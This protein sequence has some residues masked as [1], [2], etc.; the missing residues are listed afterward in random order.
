MDSYRVLFEPLHKTICVGSK[1]TL[2]EAA[3]KAGIILD[4]VCGGGRGCGRCKVVVRDGKVR[5]ETAKRLAPEE[6]ERGF[7]LACRAYPESDLLIEIP[8]ETHSADKLELDKDARRFRAIHPGIT[9]KQFAKSPLVRKIF[10]TLDRPTLD[11]NPGDYERLQRALKK[12]TG[13]S[14]VH[15]DLKLLCRLPQVLRENDFAVTVTVGTLGDTA[16]ILDIEGGNRSGRNCMA[17]VDVGTSTI[18]VHLVDAVEMTTLDAHACYN[19][20]SI[21][22]RE[23]TAR[24][25]ASEKR[26]GAH[27]QELVVGDINRL[28][29]AL[30][31]KNRIRLKDILA[32]VAAG[33]TTMAHFLL[34]LP[35]GNIRRN[36]YIAASIEPPPV[37]ATEVGIRIHPAGLLFVVPGISSWVGGDLTAGI[38]A[39]DLHES[40]ET[41]MLIDVG[42]NGEIILGN[43]E[44]LVACSAST[45]PA[46][47]GASVECGMIAER[48]AI[49]KVYLED[50]RI[51]YKVI[52]HTAPRGICGSGIIDLIAALLDKGIIDRSGR[53]VE[54]SDPAVRFEKGCGRFVIVEKEKTQTGKDVFVTQNDIENVITAKAAVFAA[55]KILVERL[56]LRFSDID[57]LFLAGGFG[58]YIDRHNAI[59]IGLLPDLPVSRIHYVGNT[60]LWGAKLAAFSSEAYRTL[61]E[62]RLKTTY[63]DLIGTSD[64]V[65]QF[66]Q[67]MFLPHTDIEL[68]PSLLDRETSAA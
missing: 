31:R 32:V 59:K 2:L 35:A 14:S 5:S 8:E 47:E 10:L 7:V 50:D 58:S 56:N 60:S 17:I 45:G 66:K 26:G 40:N 19:S 15:A 48:G 49:E 67:A 51:H 22:G 46:L 21:Y 33:N 68:F 63:Y 24:I 3:A 65:E 30:A 53:L 52:G 64:Y 61:H 13:I 55:A 25:I 38:L 43:K 9:Q 36:P 62:I 41:V 34:G 28:I 11:D 57:K 29:S 4:K 12:T 27:L 42:T 1:T 37:R 23:V 39:T 16:E 6:I 44:W 54:G 20:Q 18:V